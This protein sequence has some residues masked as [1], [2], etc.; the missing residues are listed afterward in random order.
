MNWPPDITLHLGRL[1][2]HMDATLIHLQ[3]IDRRL[4]HGDD[5]MD[6]LQDAAHGLTRAVDGVKSEL[7]AISEIKRTVETLAADLKTVRD[8][9]HEVST[10]ERL[11]KEALRFAVPLAVLWATGSIDAAVKMMGALR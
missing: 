11:T 1:S 7:G 10:A 9:R 2:G 6:E 8:G 4:E 5:R 3:R